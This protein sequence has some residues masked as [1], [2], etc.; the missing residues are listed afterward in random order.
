MT[1]APNPAA[2]DRPN[3]VH[4]LFAEY[5]DLVTLRDR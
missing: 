3:T 4:G 2:Y 1:D 5:V